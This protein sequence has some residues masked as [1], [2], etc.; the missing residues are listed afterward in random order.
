MSLLEVCPLHRSYTKS[1]NSYRMLQST[2]LLNNLNLRSPIHPHLPTHTHTLLLALRPQEVRGGTQVRQASRVGE[3]EQ[4]PPPPPGDHGDQL[5]LAH[6]WQV[7]SSMVGA[8]RVQGQSE[9]APPRERP[10]Q[11]AASARQGSRG[12]C[13]PAVVCC[14]LNVTYCK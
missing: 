14:T 9:L 12:R 13:E 1:H 5:R 8:F 10:T 11:G 7:P 4:S 6:R 3:W 2:Y